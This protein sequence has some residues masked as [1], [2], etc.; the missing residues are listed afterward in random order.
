MGELGVERHTDSWFTEI[1]GTAG[2]MSSDA[3]EWIDV[4]VGTC[5]RSLLIASIF[6]CKGSKSISREGGQRKRRWN[7]GKEGV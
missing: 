7:S 1:G 4:L 2:Y 3:G 6:F 5:G